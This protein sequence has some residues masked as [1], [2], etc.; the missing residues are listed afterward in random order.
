MREKTFEIKLSLDFHRLGS[1]RLHYML[2]WETG[3]FA[4]RIGVE[5][6]LESFGGPYKYIS[7][8]G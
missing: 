1:V 5:F 7:S 4:L 8:H 6:G 3:D 2:M